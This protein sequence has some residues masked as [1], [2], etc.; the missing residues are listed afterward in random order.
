MKRN[1]PLVIILT[2]INFLTFAS[3][4]IQNAFVNDN[5]GVGSVYIRVNNAISRDLLKPT[6]DLL[7]DHYSISGVGPDDRF[8]SEIDIE[9]QAKRI[10]DLYAGRWT[11]TILGK[12]S[13]DYVLGSSVVSVDVIADDVV[14]SN[15]NVTLLEGSGILS[16]D[17]SWP[18]GYVI[19]PIVN[20]VIENSAGVQTSFAMDITNNAATYT[21]VLEQGYYTL[22]LQFSDGADLLWGTTKTVLIMKGQTTAGAEALEVGALD[23]ITG[24]LAMVINQSITPDYTVQINGI[25]RIYPGSDIELEATI[26]YAPTYSTHE[27]SYEWY[28]NGSK[29]STASTNRLNIGQ[30]L[31]LGEHNLSVI[32]MAGQMKNSSS[33]VLSVKYL[34]K[35]IGPAGGYITYVDED[36][37]F[38]WNYIEIAFLPSLTDSPKASWGSS[39]NYIGGTQTGIGTGKANTE[40]ILAVLQNRGE[41]GKAAQVANNYSVTVNDVVYDD[42]FLPSRNELN[43]AIYYKLVNGYGTIYSSSEVDADYVQM[44]PSRYDS[45]TQKRKEDNVPYS[46][47]PIRYF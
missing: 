25:Q 20:G 9:G 43:A 12:N 27:F 16:L 38:D 28:I 3:C 42:W 2:V 47:L 19:N 37:I 14:T 44:D 35:D 24:D 30:D 33:A 6:I 46:V 31:P 7:I 34:P 26:I 29:I 41:T 32:A 1:I 4:D 45:I 36:N 10:D 22:S 23:I 13:E 18:E 15:V 17:L 40:L 8:F 21:K 11:F 39:G 5:V